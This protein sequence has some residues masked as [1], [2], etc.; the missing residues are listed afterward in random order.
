MREVDEYIEWD[1]KTVDEYTEQEL[2]KMAS[3]L[4]KKFR[5]NYRKRTS[6]SRSKQNRGD[7]S[8]SLVESLL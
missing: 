2:K 5:A 7:G 3:D 1:K 8:S 4:Q 6:K